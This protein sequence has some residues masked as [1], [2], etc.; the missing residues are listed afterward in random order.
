MNP[1]LD[2][3]EPPAVTVRRNALRGR[4]A[5]LRISTKMLVAVALVAVMAGVIGVTALSRMSTMNEDMR[6]MGRANTNQAALGEVRA[7]MADMYN[8]SVGAVLERAPEKRAERT[9]QVHDYTDQ[10]TAAFEAY[11]ADVADYQPL[12]Q[13]LAAFE[14]V[15][16]EFE[17]LRD[18]VMFGAPLPAGSG[19][20]LAQA[21]TRLGETSMEL[22]VLMDKLVDN[23]RKASEMMVAAG[24][25]GYEDARVSVIV[26]LTVGL[27]LS[28]VVALLIARTMVGTLRKLSQTLSAMARGDL[29]RTVEVTSR[30]EVG[31]MAVA[32]NQ[33]TGSMRRAMEALAT[34]A[35]TLAASSTELSGVSDRIAA[36][37][38]EAS[39]QAG[40]VAAAAGQVSHNVQTVSAGSEE[41]GASIREIA[42]NAG[43]GAKVASKAVEVAASTNETVAKL[44]ASSAEIGSVIKTI[45]SIAEQTNLLAL[46]AT[47]EAARAGDA[48]KGFAV[49]AGEVKD[50]AQETAKATEDISKRVEAIQADTESAVAAIAEISAIIG[51]IND[52]QLTIAG[53]VEEQTATTGEMNRSVAEAAQGSADIAANISVLAG[54]ARVT[55][56]GVG[57]SQRAAAELAGLSARLHT[58]VSGFRY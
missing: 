58:L 15:W 54:A 4:F 21:A 37:A 8:T 11:R 9:R 51:R 53:A 5:D 52:Y 24:N 46:N 56:E 18:A 30:D 31:E 17:V 12:Q 42:H 28:V 25:A 44:G 38:D 45:T 20:D 36:S 50:L 26:L 33:A 55:A 49:V 16:Q 43:E 39:T 2:R 13:D 47:I 19:T 29:T 6:S 10:V 1:P 27:A 41:M 57:E 35:D 22:N 34:S 3:I 14:E 48:G 40:N 23:E 32:V 7:R